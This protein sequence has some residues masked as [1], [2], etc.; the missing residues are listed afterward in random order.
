MH[1]MFYDAKKLI[2]LDVSA[3]DTS[4][5]ERMS[6]MFHGLSSLTILDVSGWDTSSVTN[7]NHPFFETISLKELVLGSNFSF[8]PLLDNIHMPVFGDMLPAIM[9]QAH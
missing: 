8:V 5:V 4:S 1:N 7:M 6:G 9:E 3:W 2:S